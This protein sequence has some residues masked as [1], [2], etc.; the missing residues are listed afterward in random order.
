MENGDQI[1]KRNSFRAGSIEDLNVIKA[2]GE[3]EEENSDF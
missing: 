1:N 2:K 3:E